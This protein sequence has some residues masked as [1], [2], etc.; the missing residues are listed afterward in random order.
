[1]YLD[2]AAREYVVFKPD[3][4]LQTSGS[5]VVYVAVLLDAGGG[6]EGET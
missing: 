5:L 2:T 1:M 3:I 4:S 6:E